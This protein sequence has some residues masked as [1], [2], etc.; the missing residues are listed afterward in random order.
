MASNKIEEIIDI[1]DR[2]GVI[3]PRDI[4]KNRIP[5]QYIYRLYAEGKL[6]KVARG[7]YKL[8]EKELAED[9]MVLEVA[10]KIPHATLCLLSALRFHDMTTQNPFQIWIAI[11]HKDWAPEIDLP[12]RIIRM[13]GDALEEGR[14]E[15]YIDNVKINVY[16]PAKTVADCFK[17]RN[18]IGLDVSLEALRDYKMQRKGTMDDLWKYSKI[19]RVQKIISPYIESLYE[20]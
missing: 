4:E 5:R 20:S 17:F 8:P 13:T 16:N 7:L 14:E 2:N 9:V 12:L 15:H 11:H 19:D 18:K 6:E 3:R 10:K 1:A